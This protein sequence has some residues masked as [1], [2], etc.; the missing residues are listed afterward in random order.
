METTQKN[1]AI[2]GAGIM[3][4][5]AAYMLAKST[6]SAL[7]I[8]EPNDIPPDNASFAAGGMLAPYSEIEHMPDDFIDAATIYAE[9]CF[10]IH[11]LI[12]LRVNLLI[13]PIWRC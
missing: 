9:S 12:G 1:I 10:L 13:P 2:I 11:F 7:T 6:Q 4:L 3:G 5:S 8:F